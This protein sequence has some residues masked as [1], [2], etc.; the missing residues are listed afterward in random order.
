MKLE[1]SVRKSNAILMLINFLRNF[2]LKYYDKT[3]YRTH[4]KPT[5]SLLLAAD[6][7][8]CAVLVLFQNENSELFLY[9]KSM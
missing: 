7:G 9:K 6:I 8:A 1:Y 2:H 3:S 4:A 5:T